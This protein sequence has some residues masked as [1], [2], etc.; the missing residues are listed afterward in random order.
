M[1]MGTRK[2]RTRQEA[3][4]Y[5]AE[6]AEAPGH[7]F[8]PR[9]NRILDESGFKAFCEERCRNFYHEKLGRPSL[10]PACVSG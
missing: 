8:Y 5:H 1:A 6:I 4:W 3:L 7:P 9:L 10:A 2:Q